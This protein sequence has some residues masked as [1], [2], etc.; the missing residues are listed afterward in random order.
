MIVRLLLGLLGLAATA[1][2]SVGRIYKLLCWEQMGDGSGEEATAAS[3]GS[4][5]EGK[6]AA[7]RR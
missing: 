7:N 1:G 3:E 6:K 4:R 2:E 5:L